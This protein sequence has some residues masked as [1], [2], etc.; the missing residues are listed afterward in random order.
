MAFFYEPLSRGVWQTQRYITRDK[1][2]LAVFTA[3]LFATP[4]LI[5]AVSALI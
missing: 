5:I 3:C 1:T 4:L 2:R